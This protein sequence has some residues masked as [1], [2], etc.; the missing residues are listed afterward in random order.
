MDA[1]SGGFQG[2]VEEFALLVGD[3]GVLIAVD[4][5]EWRVV[6]GD[7]GDGVGEGG[8]FGF[9]LNGSAEEE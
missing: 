1:E 9:F 7:V 3:D 5:E 6:R 2:F 4:D 8:F